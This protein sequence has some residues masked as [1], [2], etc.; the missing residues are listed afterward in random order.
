MTAERMGLDVDRDERF[1]G[2]PDGIYHFG[3]ERAHDM[4]GPPLGRW[5]LGR[6]PIVSGPPPRPVD[7]S[8][9]TPACP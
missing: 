7:G 6:T 1:D 2:R 4:W 9:A 8:A 5:W 3:V